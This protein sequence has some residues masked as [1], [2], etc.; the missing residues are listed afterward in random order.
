MLQIK[1]F[2]ETIFLALKLSRYT[3]PH[4]QISLLR[5]Q[6]RIVIKPILEYY[7]YM[8]MV[9][10][11]CVKPGA[12]IINTLRSLIPTIIWLKLGTCNIQSEWIL[13]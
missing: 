4:P 12:N 13:E 11:K 2:E 3:H 7:S 6:L 8:I 9:A 5:W 1:A 10:E